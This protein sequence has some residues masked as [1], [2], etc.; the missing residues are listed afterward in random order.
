MLDARARGKNAP[1]V[2]RRVLA[3]M[4]GV[5][6]TTAS[7]VAGCTR[8]VAAG[9]D[10]PDANRA[11]V[12]LAKAGVEADKEADPA[13]EGRFRLVV[14]RDEATVAIAVL[15]GEEIPRPKP[16]V[17]A[18]SPLVT[19]PEADRAARVAA[20]ASQLERSLAS[21]DGV[22]D[23]RV[24]LD[25]PATDP[26]GAALAGDAKLPRPTASVLLRHRGAQSPVAEA[27]VRRL[28]S[29]AVSGLAATDVAVVMVPVSAAPRAGDRELAHVG[30]IAVTRGSLGTLKVTLAGALGLVSV[31]SL[32][33]LVL[34][35]RLRR[36]RDGGGQPGAEPS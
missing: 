34:A 4:A 33:V 14:G 12:A 3:L 13:A 19:S 30:P 6:A 5:V 36:A 20:T 21:I 1:M 27:E 11:V 24:H 35:S 7:L 25:V 22:H 32:A 28:V 10:E 23:A 31:L 2:P 9:L 18:A 17:A 16:P 26:L 15:A 29:G 8:E